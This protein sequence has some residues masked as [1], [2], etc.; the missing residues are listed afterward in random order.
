[1]Y[2]TPDLGASGRVGT[3][4]PA[5]GLPLESNG[6]G[7]SVCDAASSSPDAVGIL[8]WG[9]NPPEKQIQENYSMAKIKIENKITSKT[10]ARKKY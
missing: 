6:V 8:V 2:Q 3:L 4:P 9:A 1:M 10:N 7:M 5:P